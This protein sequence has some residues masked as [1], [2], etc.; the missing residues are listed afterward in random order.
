MLK[1]IVIEAY[2]VFTR[3]VHSLPHFTFTPGERELKQIDGFISVLDKRFGTESIGRSFIF[4][5]M[6]FQ[7]DY[8]STL[9]HQA[10][11]RIPLNWV[12]GKK[13]LVRWVNRTEDDLYHSLKYASD[14]GIHLGMIKTGVKRPKMDYHAIRL[15]EEKE[16]ERFHNTPTGMARVEVSSSKVEKLRLSLQSKLK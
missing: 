16:K 5:F 15:H 11:K 14:N 4:S 6:A 3:K 2:E 8:Y 12:A 13:G 9:D 7:Y 1:E 10:K